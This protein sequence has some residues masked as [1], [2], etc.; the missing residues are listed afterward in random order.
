MKPNWKK[1]EEKCT[2]KLKEMQ[3]KIK[4]L[5]WVENRLL[6]VFLYSYIFLGV[7]FNEKQY[8]KSKR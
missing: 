1:K 6:I 2:E 7:C 5:A 4:F 8:N 3:G